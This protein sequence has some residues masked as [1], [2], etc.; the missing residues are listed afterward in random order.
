MTDLETFRQSLLKIIE[1]L[2]DLSIENEVYYDTILE[3]GNINFP[4]SSETW[5]PQRLILRNEQRFVSVTPKRGKV[6]PM[7]GFAPTPLT[8]LQPFQNPTSQIS[9]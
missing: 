7:L 5:K 9:H 1:A 8:C 3:S 4:N 2:E 6:F